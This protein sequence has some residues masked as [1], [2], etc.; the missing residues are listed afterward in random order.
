MR[1]CNWE[2]SGASASLRK[3]L[4]KKLQRPRIIGLP[5]PENGLLSHCWVPIR[6]CDF[7]QFGHAFIL[8]QLAERK[9]SF[10]LHFRVRIVLDR[11]G[12]CAH[13]FLS[14]FLRQPEERLSSH[15]R[16]RVVVRHAN[17]FIQRSRF[18]AYR[19]RKR[20]LRAHV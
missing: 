10:F 20:Y 17:Y 3:H 11:S 4:C 15:V 18:T 9:D 1:A 19:E 8:W 2:T 7:D 13:C 5:K 14:C 16:A 6:L 12:Y